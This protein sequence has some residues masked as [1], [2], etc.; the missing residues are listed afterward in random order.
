LADC[1]TL[2]RRWPPSILKP[3]RRHE[4]VAGG[5]RRA[6]KPGAG[7]FTDGQGDGSAVAETRCDFVK[8]PFRPT[9][10]GPV[11]TENRRDECQNDDEKEPRK[12]QVSIVADKTPPLAMPIRV[13]LH[14]RTSFKTQPGQ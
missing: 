3:N 8:P 5:V 6:D 9:N 4:A 1:A 11:S 14:W 10:L 7:R 13:G 12:E 2:K